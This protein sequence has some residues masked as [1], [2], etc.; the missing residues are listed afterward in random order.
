MLRDFWLIAGGILPCDELG[1]GRN[2]PADATR[3]CAGCGR[4][5]PADAGRIS[6]VVRAQL[7]HFL[8]HRR[9]RLTA[10]TCLL[11]KRPPL[12]SIS[13]DPRGFSPNLGHCITQYS[14]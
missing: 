5:G 4:N 12:C 7:K 10:P 2:G 3:I 11:R 8:A 9:Q 6:T 13:S 14:V 1:R